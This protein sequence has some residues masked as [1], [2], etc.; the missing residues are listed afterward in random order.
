[1]NPNP[2]SCTSRLIVPVVAM[3]SPVDAPQSAHTHNT[4]SARQPLEYLEALPLPVP[5]PAIQLEHLGKRYG[6]GVTALRDL[7]LEIAPGEVFGFLGL[8]GAGKTTTIRILLDLV[9]PTAGN[10]AV[11]GHDCQS[12][13]LKTRAAV[14]YLPGE[15]GVYSDLT[16][17]ELLAFLE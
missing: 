3:S 1:M 2:L 17:Y 14:G 16:G 8:N 7:S 10:A 9:R 13:C 6:G 15:W 4:G 12:D 5:A 11:F